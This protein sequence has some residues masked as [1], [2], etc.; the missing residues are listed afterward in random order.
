LKGSWSDVC[1]RA[2]EYALETY[3]KYG[4]RLTLRALFYYLADAEGLIVHSQTA[5]KKLSERFARYRE[6]KGRIDVLKDTSRTIRMNYTFK[7]LYPKEWLRTELEL[8]LNRLEERWRLPKWFWQPIYLTIFIEKET[9]TLV[10]NIADEWEIDAFPTRGF[11]SVTKM[12]EMVVRLSTATNIYNKDAVLLTLTD[13]DPSGIFIER[14]YENKLEKYRVYVFRIER[15]AMKP[16]QIEKYNLPAIPHD[17]PKA[18]RVRRDPR[19][20]SWLKYCQEH[21][22]EPRVVELDAF[23]GLRPKEFRE[24]IE[25]HIKKYFDEDIEKHKKEE[26]EKLKEEVKKLKAEL[27]ERLK[28]LLTT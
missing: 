24:L 26:E 9:I 5:Y 25:A 18:E 17:D 6:E 10:E 13:F 21:G 20:P 19:Y 15:V 1:K 14:D 16:E 28:D 8:L 27:I 22:I 2:M 23:A 3:E 7:V 4:I 11:A 12:W